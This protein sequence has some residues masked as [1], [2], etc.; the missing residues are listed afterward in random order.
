MEN[1][2]KANTHAQKHR[3]KKVSINSKSVLSCVLFVT[4]GI[5]L[6]QGAVF[7]TLYP[8]GFAIISASSGIYSFAAFVG[9]GIGLIFSQT[10]IY[11]FR[12]AVCAAALWI[13]R[14]RFLSSKVRFGKVWFF[15]MFVCFLVCTLTGIAVVFPTGGG[16][17]EILTFTAEGFIASL[18]TFF[19][20]KCF[21]AFSGLTNSEKTFSSAEI[22]CI[23]ISLATVIAAL[24]IHDFYGFSPAVFFSVLAITF[25]SHILSESGGGICAAAC[26]AA[27]A[28]AS[29]GNFNIFPL[30]LSGAACGI[31]SPLGKIGCATS[32]FLTYAATSAFTEKEFAMQNIICSLAAIIVFLAVPNKLYLKSASVFKRSSVTLRESSCG[33]E[34]SQKLSETAQAVLSICD[35]MN[36]VSENLKKIDSN[37]DRS[38]FCRVKQEVCSE[39]ENSE[40][41]WNSGFKYTL[42]GFEELSENSRSGREFDSTP[43]AKLFLSKCLKS[44][45]VKSSLIYNF[46]RYDN[47]LQNEIRLNEKRSLISEQMKCTSSILNEFSEKF[48]VCSLVDNELSQKVKEIFKSFSIRCTKALCIIDKEGNMTIKINCKKIDVD[49][50]R[51][52]LKK[53]IE[54]AALRKF[55]DPEID[56]TEN[57]TSVI[58][59]QKPWMNIKIGKI[60]LSSEESPL[61][62][63]CMRESCDRFGNKTIII[64]DGMGTG[65]RA[66]VD[67]AMTAEYFGKLIENSLS[68]DSA[69]KI[70]NSVLSVKSTNESLATIDAL[71]LNL[72]SGK[73]EFFKA[74]AAVS[75]VRKRGKCFTVES[76][77]LPAGILN[78][79]SFAKESVM[80]SKG[81]IV[82]M[83]SDGVTNYQT[84]WI[85]TEIEGFNRSDPN[86]LAQ[87]IAGTVCDKSH[88]EK[89]DDITVVV[90]I[91]TA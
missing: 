26:C 55:S 53:E 33:N 79:V 66:A 5:I 60:Q 43:F 18:C 8:F 69:L 4:L 36:K 56:F 15:P 29:S 20:H 88:G 40:K 77:S 19:Y 46:K 91:M 71:H 86:I 10:G 70:V 64:S 7:E 13:I 48:A 25:F 11:L 52:K 38:I 24:G 83:V 41:C 57:G 74:G 39:C 16:L 31:F 45:E 51:K 37:C 78:D 32:F 49:V 21:R 42:R 80:L 34:A 68:F 6:G 54:E 47:T 73:A 67:A 82:V 9:T 89:R 59:R 84:D 65:G 62:G 30:M 22:T 12:Y 28:G 76:A 17:A 81:D 75:F 27:L 3:D 1:F 61:C 44:N 87:K 2:K 35:G 58:Y 90:G 72:F 23:Y 14:I 50:D 85:K 63:D